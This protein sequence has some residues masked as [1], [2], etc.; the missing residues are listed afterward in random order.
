MFL[1]AFLT[2]FLLSIH[3]EQYVPCSFNFDG[4]AIHW[5]RLIAFLN[6]DRWIRNSFIYLV[7]YTT[8][9]LDDCMN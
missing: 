3:N 6:A 2:A 4:Y 7:R 8:D 1:F 5:S 9:D